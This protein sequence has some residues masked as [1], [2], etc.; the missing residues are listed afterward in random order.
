MYNAWASFTPHI[1]RPS[2]C[3]CV[4]VCVL[5]FNINLENS[6]CLNSQWACMHS[7]W[8]GVLFWLYNIFTDIKLSQRMAWW[9]LRLNSKC[10]VLQYIDIAFQAWLVCIDLL[11]KNI[12]G[13]TIINWLTRLKWRQIEVC[14]FKKAF[15]EDIIMNTMSSIAK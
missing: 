15:I 13:L 1:L 4:C 11:N 14:S 7:V 5:Y 9:H 12:I 8:Y 6:M 10:K 3:V 2:V